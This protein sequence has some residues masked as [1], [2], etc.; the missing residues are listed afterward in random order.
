MNRAI[1]YCDNKCKSVGIPTQTELPSRICQPCEKQLHR[2]LRDIPDHYALLPIF[3][4]HGTAERNPDSKATKRSEAPAPM[5]L[6]II[7]LLDS[8]L[9]RRWNGTAPAHDRRGVVGTLTVHTERLREERRLTAPHNDTNV[10]Q[11]CD[12]LSRH[13]L[14]LSEQDWI[15]YL[16]A[17]IKQIHKAL[18]DAIGE[19]RRPSVG[20]CHIPT[21]DE[22][23]PCGGPLFANTYGGVHC[24]RCRAVWDAG[25]LRQLGLAQQAATQETV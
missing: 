12:L 10:T 11:A 2:W 17:D 4:E 18:A 14:W 24:A 3:L 6:E 23:T 13:I 20:H 8:R 16:Y 15:G 25:H 7:D 21:T 19:Y 1:H 22:G 5:R 9:G